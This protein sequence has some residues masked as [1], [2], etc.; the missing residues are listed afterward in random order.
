MEVYDFI[1]QAPTDAAL[2]DRKLPPWSV[3]RPLPPFQCRR[4]VEQDYA[5][6]YLSCMGTSVPYKY[7][8]QTWEGEAENSGQTLWLFRRKGV[9]D[10]VV[11]KTTVAS[12][13]ACRR[14][15]DDVTGS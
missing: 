12:I 1:C 8:L 2:A 4:M 9:E 13:A 3:W 7:G 15:L 10:M 11:R 6:L 14:F 5:V